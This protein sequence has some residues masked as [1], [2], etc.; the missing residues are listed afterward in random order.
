MSHWK[1]AD[2]IMGLMMMMMMMM[3]MMKTIYI[4][5]DYNEI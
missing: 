3:M 4:D 2:G 1:R 5:T